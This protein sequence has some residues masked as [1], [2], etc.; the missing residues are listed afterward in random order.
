[1]HKNKIVRNSILKLLLNNS[2]IILTEPL[3]Y[4]ELIAT[5]KICHFILT[6]SGGIQEEAPSLGKPVLVL[7]NK[8]ER[9]EAIKSGTAK[10]VGTDKFK[11][12]NESIKLINDK[13]YYDKMSKIKNPY[14]EGNASN[15]IVDIC[16]S[17]FKGDI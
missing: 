1:M 3:K 8:T 15:L 9:E 10:L 14:G 13:T 7:R 6:D 11:I 4:D 12:I 16:E 2:K 5:M 17:F